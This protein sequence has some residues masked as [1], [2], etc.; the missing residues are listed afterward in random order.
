MARRAGRDTAG[1]A[2]LDQAHDRRRRSASVAGFWIAGLRRV[3][4]GDIGER[5]LIQGLGD[6]GHLLMRAAAG[7]VV[8]ELL[9]DRRARLT[10]QIGIFG[11]TDTPCSPWQATQTSCALAR[12]RSGLASAR[13]CKT[14]R[15]DHLRDR[16]R[17]AVGHLLARRRSRQD[18]ERPAD[19]GV[20]VDPVAASLHHRN[21]QHAEENAA[22]HDAEN[23]DAGPDPPRLIEN[24]RFGAMSPSSQAPS[25]SDARSPSATG[26]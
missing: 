6:V 10:G 19:G 20:G 7:S 26:R 2:E 21:D 22:E 16:R 9:V 14:R 15:P 13:I 1:I 24:M 23:G 8:V 17:R 25:K 3:I 12:P 5:G 4:G 18:A 11:A